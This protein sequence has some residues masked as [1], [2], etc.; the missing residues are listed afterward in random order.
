VW[1][2]PTE[3]GNVLASE[4]DRVGGSVD[5]AKEEGAAW[6]RLHLQ[7]DAAARAT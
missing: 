5:L 4:F 1:I 6:H 2:E 3:V 7:G